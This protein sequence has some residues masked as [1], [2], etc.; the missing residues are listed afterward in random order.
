[1]CEI[2]KDELPAVGEEGFG[3]RNNSHAA[4]GHDGLPP[5]LNALVFAA[6]PPLGSFRDAT[7][8]RIPLQKSRSR[9]A[10]YFR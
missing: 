1:L 4:I 9:K 7:S 10:W 6:R 2:G 8:H 5:I 3:D